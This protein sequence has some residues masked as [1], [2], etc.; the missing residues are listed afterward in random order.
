MI[1]R[2]ARDGDGRI[3]LA[4]ERRDGLAGL[5]GVMMAPEGFV[6]GKANMPGG[7][8]NMPR[9]THPE[10]EVADILTVWVQDAEMVGGHHS[11]R[12]VAR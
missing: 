6:N 7:D 12:L 2:I 11:A 5:Q 3:D 9:V 1:V 8:A 10:I 4:H